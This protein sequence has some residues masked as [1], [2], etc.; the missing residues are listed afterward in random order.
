MEVTQPWS[1]PWTQASPSPRLPARAPR[2]VE[3]YTRGLSS[4]SQFLACWTLPGSSWE[5]EVEEVNRLITI[6]AHYT[7]VQ[8]WQSFSAWFAMSLR[9]KGQ[10][11]L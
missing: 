10:G 11:L 2:R 1:S 9:P 6:P 4:H 5:A 3:C 8:P 7:T